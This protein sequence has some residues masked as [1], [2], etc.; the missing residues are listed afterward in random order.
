MEGLRKCDEELEHISTPEMWHDILD[1]NDG[2]STKVARRATWY[3]E[4]RQLLQ[5]E[6]LRCMEWERKRQ[7]D[8]AEEMYQ[9]DK[10]LAYTLLNDYREHI[11]RERWITYG[12]EQPDN[13]DRS[14]MD[15]SPPTPQRALPA[16]PS[17]AP[18][19]SHEELVN[20]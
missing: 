18:S 13:G 9:R 17:P 1:K 19:V 12:T 7:V 8:L 16:P 2:N 15:G 4:R 10:F 14:S 11:H 5:T 6:R 20:H 3:D